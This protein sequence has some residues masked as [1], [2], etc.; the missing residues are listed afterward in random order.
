[1]DFLEGI[2]RSLGITILMITHD[3]HLMLEY[4]KRAIV[5][6]GGNLVADDRSSHVLTDD[7]ITEHASL[8]KTSLYDLSIK[9]GIDT[10][11]EFIDKF[12]YE[13]RRLRSAHA[14]RNGRND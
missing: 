7:F 12:I 5:L 8:K 3:M 6:S 9:C 11:G 10:P 4:T 14:G 13:D 1:M 2:N